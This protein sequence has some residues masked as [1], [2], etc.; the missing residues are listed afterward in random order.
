MTRYPLAL[1]ALLLSLAGCSNTAST[2]L[3]ETTL[4]ENALAEDPALV[5]SAE[6][7]AAT[8]ETTVEVDPDYAAMR[9]SVAAVGDIM[10][11]TDFPEN[12]LADDDGAGYLAAV[13]PLL[14]SAD[15]TFGNLEGV[16]L[17]GGEPAKKCSNP[18]AC[19]LFRSPPH[20]AMH[21]KKAGFDFMSLANNHARD[22][23]EAGR[24][25]S[26]AALDTAGI[27]H[28]G[29]EGS[30]ASWLQGELRIA[31]IAFSPTK[32][33]WP[34]LSI[35]VAEEAVADLAREHDIVIV[36]FHGGAEGVEGSE[37]L[38]FGMEW[39]YGEKRGDVVD[40]SR[41]V[42]DAGADL[43]IGHG[44]H[45]P[46]AMELYKQRLIAYSLG[47]F[48]TYY[49]ISV[50]GAKGY[51]PVLVAE[52]DGNGRFTGGQL[53]S[54]IQQRPNGPRSDAQQ[55]ALNM[56]RELTALDFPQSELTIDTNGTLMQRR[57][58]NPTVEPAP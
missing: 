4:V 7:P 36:S 46:R 52:L 15:I 32:G 37:R 54:Y 43:V 13:T 48:A 40:F 28:S 31:L 45:V 21:L 29:R 56:I 58:N 33:S 3:A 16:L 34:L 55:R 19:Y 12:R 39:A 11:G 6:Q 22:F 42:I 8:A 10:L 23:G 50:S 20:Y 44:P 27:L 24:D 35:A 47:N 17:N 14:Q 57:G 18:K 5:R 53:H 30:V 38:G 1:G 41:R 9:L 51:A 25:A 26:M 49:G 2:A